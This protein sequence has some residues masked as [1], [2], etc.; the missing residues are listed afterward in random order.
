MAV[1]HYYSASD[2]IQGKF[3]TLHTFTNPGPNAYALEV[4]GDGMTAAEGDSFPHGSL[5]VIDPDL[6]ARNGDYVIAKYVDGCSIFMQYFEDGEKIYFKT[7][8]PKYPAIKKHR[9]VC[10]CG[11]V[12]EAQSP[13]YQRK[14]DKKL[15]LVPVLDIPLRH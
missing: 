3:P 11:V 1:E 13:L 15:R 8:N 10:I 2:V 9:K 7:L 5:I 4:F 12:V 14:A 6:R